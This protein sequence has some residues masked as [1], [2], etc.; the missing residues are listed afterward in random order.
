QSSSGGNQEV[1]GLGRALTPGPGGIGSLRRP[2]PA[3]PDSQSLE[4]APPDDIRSRGE[5]AG[6]GAGLGL[7]CSSD[8]NLGEAHCRRMSEAD[9]VAACLTWLR[10]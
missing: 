1:R 8:P 3:C 2:A 7:R 6:F 5:A 9:L 10:R 4:R